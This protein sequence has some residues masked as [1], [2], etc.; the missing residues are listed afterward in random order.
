MGRSMTAVGA[1]PKD[2]KEQGS[3]DGLAVIITVPAKTAKYPPPPPSTP[4]QATARVVTPPQ[5]VTGIPSNQDGVVRNVMKEPTGAVV[6]G[7]P[8]LGSDC[9]LFQVE[10]TLDRSTLSKAVTTWG[11][12]SLCLLGGAHIQKQ[13]QP[14]Q[15]YLMVGHVNLKRVRQVTS[16]FTMTPL[17]YS[18]SSDSQNTL[19]A[20]DAI[21]SINGRPIS[22]M[23]TSIQDV[24]LTLRNMNQMTVQALRCS[25]LHLNITPTVEQKGG[26]KVARHAYQCLRSILSQKSTHHPSSS[27]SSNND[28]GN[29]QNRNNPRRSLLPQLSSTSADPRMKQLPHACS[30]VV[31]KSVPRK[32]KQQEGGVFFNHISFR[33]LYE[34]CDRRILINPLFGMEYSDN[35]EFDP[36]EGTRAS[37]FLCRDMDQNFGTWLAQRKAT[38]WRPQWKNIRPIAS[39]QK[40]KGSNSSSFKWKPPSSRKRTIYSQLNN[41]MSSVGTGRVIHRF[42]CQDIEECFPSWLAK[43][44]GTWRQTWKIQALTHGDE[45]GESSLCDGNDDEV[46]VSADFWTQQGYSTFQDWLMESKRKWTRQYSWNQNKRRK[47]VEETQE[48]VHFPSL[49]EDLHLRAQTS[50]FQKWLRV[51]K[52]HWLISRR[53]RQRFLHEQEYIATQHPES[54]ENMGDCPNPADREQEVNDNNT[55]HSRSTDISRGLRIAAGETISGNIDRPSP[56]SVTS[57][58]RPVKRRTAMMTTSIMDVTG[59]D[60]LLEEQDERKKELESQ[61]PMDV[62]FVFDPALGAPDDVIALMFRFLDPSEHW[63]FLCVSHETSSTIQTRTYMWQQLCPKHWILPRRPRKPWHNLYMTRIREDEEER[64]HL[65]DGIL[66]KATSILNKGD[67]LLKIE[68]LVGSSNHSFPINYTSGIVLERNSLL[69]IAVI[70][71][72][73]KVVKWLID[74]HGANMETQDRG[75]FTPLINAAWAGDKYLVRYLMSKGCDRTKIGTGHYSHPLAHPDFAGHTAEGWARKRGFPEIAELIRLGL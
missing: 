41:G 23:G 5:P 58:S 4:L 73:H 42:L 53:K 34:T 12:Y 7:S 64:R 52:K 51:R 61:P 39:P 45:D 28:N 68:R 59:I 63:K 44:K 75:S 32:R 33:V 56:K 69:N 66:T 65:A 49:H 11:L 8:L 67:H 26:A 18:S 60:A 24:K 15:S 19:L 9:N 16:R 35:E 57:L 17:S 29:N 50:Q 72:R 46:V 36:M 47:L 30:I 25:P 20:G 21:V 70:F 37:M 74:T 2:E 31:Q 48:V 27:S 14:A 55:S 62:Q 43:R 22:S 40:D 6:P 1:S 3:N 13:P 10:T 71:K 54:K 38:L